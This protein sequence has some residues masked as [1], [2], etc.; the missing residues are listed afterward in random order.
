MGPADPLTI[1]VPVGEGSRQWTSRTAQRRVLLVVHNVTSGLQESH[2]H[3]L[4]E[5]PS[6]TLLVDAGGRG[7]DARADGRRVG[8]SANF[9]TAESLPSAPTTR[10][11]RISRS[12]PGVDAR[13]P[14]VRPASR[15]S[16]VT[17]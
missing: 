1:R 2:V 11:A 15:T 12:P 16:P 4:G 6:R 9:A 3:G 7:R 13:T 17:W 14:T 8:T 10:R 5:Q